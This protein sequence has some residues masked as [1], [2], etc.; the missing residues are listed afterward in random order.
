MVVS[1]FCR[2]ETHMIRN[3]IR[4]ASSA[5]NRGRLNISKTECCKPREINKIEPCMQLKTTI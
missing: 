1:E 3:R 4:N 2:F 5:E